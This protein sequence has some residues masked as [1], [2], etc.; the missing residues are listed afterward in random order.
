MGRETV[1]LTSL[2]ELIKQ[3]T[4]GSCDMSQNAAANQHPSD[5]QSV[6]VEGR[7]QSETIVLN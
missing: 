7:I 5:A 4:S 3:M 6:M 2:H 1:T